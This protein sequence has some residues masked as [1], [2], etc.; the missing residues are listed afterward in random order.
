MLI[1]PDY[2]VIRNV[3]LPVDDERWAMLATLFIHGGCTYEPD[4][5][6]PEHPEYTDL[7]ADL[8]MAREA[9][10]IPIFTVYDAREATDGQDAT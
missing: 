3:A 2:K 7:Q 5:F 4:M 8:A 9:G 6:K 1:T 10:F